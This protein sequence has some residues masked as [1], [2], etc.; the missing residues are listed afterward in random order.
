[1]NLANVLFEKINESNILKVIEW[2]HR[3]KIPVEFL[4][5]EQIMIATKS[6]LRSPSHDPTRL[7]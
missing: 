4:T 2:A 6:Y 5:K 7:F 3:Q 1:M